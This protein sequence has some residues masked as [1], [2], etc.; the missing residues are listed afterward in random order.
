MI[1][2][3]RVL[4]EIEDKA[5]ELSRN[6]ETGEINLD[7]AKNIA[8]YKNFLIYLLTEKKERSLT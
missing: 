8:D 2:M 1:D 3:L 6:I 5:I 7:K 4:V